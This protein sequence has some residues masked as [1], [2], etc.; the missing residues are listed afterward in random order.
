MI[1]FNQSGAKCLASLAV[2]AGFTVIGCVPD[3]TYDLQNMDT[4]VTVLKE[5]SLPLPNI[6][7]IKLGSLLD[8]S[9][10]GSDQ[11]LSVNSNGDYVVSSG[12]DPTTIKGFTIED[13]AISLD[14]KG[15]ESTTQTLGGYDKIPE[16]TP[17]DYDPDDKEA[18]EAF[19]Q[20]LGYDVS[21]IDM[22][23]DDDFL[24]QEIDFEFDANFDIQD[25]PKEVSAIKS[26][27]LKAGSG[28]DLTI[29]PSGIPFRKINFKEGSKIVFPSFIKLASCNDQHFTVSDNSLV[30]NSNVDIPMGTGAGL[31]LHVDITKLDFGDGISPDQNGNLSF[32]DAKI[33]IENGKISLDPTDFT[34]NTTVIKYPK[35]PVSA[36]LVKDGEV[37]VVAEDTPVTGFTFAYGYE[38]KITG[39][40]SVVLKLSDDAAPAFD[41]SYGFDIEG[42]PD[43]LTGADI[44]LELAEIQLTLAV[45]SQL[46]FDFNLTGK[47]QA[48]DGN[49]PISG[50][51]YPIGPLTFFKDSKT[52]YSLG[53]KPD[54]ESGGVIYRHVADL[55]K[56]L[57]PVPSRVEATDFA[58]DF[59]KDWLTIPTGQSYGG[60][61]DVS[62]DA[63]LSFTENTRLALNQDIPM[64]L[65]I[66]ESVKGLDKL[67]AILDFTASNTIPLDF[68][69]DAEVLDE[70][71]K[72][73]PGTEVT[74]TG[75]IAAGKIGSPSTNPVSL[76]LKLD[77]AKKISAIRLVLDATSNADVAGT[78]LNEGQGLALDGLSLTLPDGITADIKELTGNNK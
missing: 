74:V 53:E 55:G 45:A 70:D 56:I 20:T 10:T 13:D 32:S 19:L 8:M 39:V 52:T 5:V 29:T 14:T 7:E 47:L 30:A 71:N 16:N 2:I 9:K 75:N 23:K 63:P 58:I 44:T 43:M 36:P 35:D 28:L 3:K 15:G 54:G 73:V 57:S 42:L 38:V 25:F 68:A 65:N 64:S 21:N 1:T 31:A 49:G 61:L 59:P 50:R 33:K 24:S 62:I 77:P 11:I 72:P 4:E 66:G 69:V 78:P 60:S 26:A 34:G 76:N 46:P 12:M 18:L 40:N 41:N 67:S 27:N 6:K 17:L 22:L 51:S 48:L 37:T